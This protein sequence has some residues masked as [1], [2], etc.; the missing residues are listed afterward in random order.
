VRFA[1]EHGPYGG[2]IFVCEKGKLEVNRNKFAS[3]P[4]QIAVEL[5]KKVDEV[6]E[7]KK[8]SD[9]TA[10]WQARWH[11]QNWL[12]CI[13]TRQKPAA[14]VEIGHRSISVCHMVNITRWVG[15][16]LKWDPVKEE[17]IGDDE[18]NKFVNRPRRKGYELPDLA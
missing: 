14:D 5:L 16:R 13:R 18:A 1:L 8:W 17:F 2:A 4:K 12:E 9:Q 10:L 7:E 6:M 3:N 15:R 11:L